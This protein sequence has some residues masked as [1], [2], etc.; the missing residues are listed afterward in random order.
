M[1]KGEW[2]CHLCTHLGMCRLCIELMSFFILFRTLV[3]VVRTMWCENICNVCYSV[4]SCRIW[5]CSKDFMLVCGLFEI[6]WLLFSMFCAQGAGYSG[7]QAGYSGLLGPESP[8]SYPE[9]SGP[10]AKHT[11]SWVNIMSY[12]SHLFCAHTCS[13]H[14]ISYKS[15]CVSSEIYANYWHL[16]G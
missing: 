6:C 12:A 16:W 5:V 15:F 11:F 14:C 13:P 7:L 8:G 3:I 9:S 1:T 4:L 2:K 10:A